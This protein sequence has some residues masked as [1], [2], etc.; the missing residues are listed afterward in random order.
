MIRRIRK[1][2]APDVSLDEF[3]QVIRDQFFMLLLDERR[4]VEAI[5]A[6]LEGHEQ[7]APELLALVQKVVRASGKLGPS[8][9]ERLAYVANYFVSEKEG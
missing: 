4:A 5:P 2:H 1:E 7:D 6:L 3:K 9:E 8:S